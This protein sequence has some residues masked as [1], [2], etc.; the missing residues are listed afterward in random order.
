MFV[1]G[2]HMALG[3]GDR[4]QQCASRRTRSRGGWHLLGWTATT[5][6]I[7][8]SERASAVNL[9]FVSKAAPLSPDEE[10]LWRT[11]MQ[12]LLALPRVLDRDM[13]QA[14]GLTANEY[15]T[16]MHLSEAQDH[17]LR[18]ADLANATALSASRMT[19][20]VDDLQA[21]GLVSRRTSESDG[22]GN[23]ALLTTAGLEKLVDAWPAHVASARRRV[24]DH[25]TAADVKRTAAVLDK[26]AGRLAQ[27]RPPGLA[28]RKST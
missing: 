13:V 21:R 1:Q 3:L 24:F 26:L 7:S 19:R 17:Q 10:A 15:K 4:V 2:E 25:L 12:L 28:T 20:L 5:P 6:A 9:L 23:V 14:T 22:R 18:M 11:L 27:D 8:F 16:L